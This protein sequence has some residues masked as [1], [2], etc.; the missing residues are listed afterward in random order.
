MKTVAEVRRAFW[1]AHP[2]LLTQKKSVDTRCA[3]SILWTIWPVMVR[4][5]KPWRSG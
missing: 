2:L 3:L 1:T 5:P 4:L